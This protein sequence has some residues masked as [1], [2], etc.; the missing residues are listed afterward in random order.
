[1]VAIV[2]TIA[3]LRFVS[4]VSLANINTIASIHSCFIMDIS[5]LLNPR[6]EEPLSIGVPVENEEADGRNPEMKVS[7]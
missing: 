1:V 3:Q 2:K 5:L 6:N 4:C 7:L